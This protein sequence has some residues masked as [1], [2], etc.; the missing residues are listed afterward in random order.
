MGLALA[1]PTKGDE[2]CI[3]P[4]C[5]ENVRQSHARM[6]AIGQEM[7]EYPRNAIDPEG[8]PSSP[9][10]M[11]PDWLDKKEGRKIRIHCQVRFPR[12]RSR[13]PRLPLR[14]CILLSGLW[15][16]SSREHGDNGER[17]LIITSFARPALG[18]PIVLPGSDRLPRQR[19]R[20]ESNDDV[21]GHSARGE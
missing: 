5:A 19:A 21:N 6:W 10:C 17:D 16:T 4:D 11:A 3:F 20:A 2:M 18:T 1:V 7:E 14:A 9:P 8:R 15:D 12:P 13:S